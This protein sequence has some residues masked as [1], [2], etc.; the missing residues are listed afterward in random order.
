MTSQ[1][2][3]GKSVFLKLNAE[4]VRWGIVIP[5]FEGESR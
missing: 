5:D 4:T 2:A 3:V 1:P